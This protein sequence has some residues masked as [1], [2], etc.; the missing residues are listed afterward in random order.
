MKRPQTKFHADTM[1]DSKVIRSKKSKFIS[2]SKFSCSRVFS[3][4]RY[5]IKVTTDFD[6]FLQVL[7][8]MWHK[9][10]FFSTCGLNCFNHNSTIEYLGV[11]RQETWSCSTWLSKCS[12]HYVCIYSVSTLYSQIRLYCSY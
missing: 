8:Q 2:R 11:V 6:M 10:V 9:N 7:L 3:R 1:W 4:Y 5:F 12:I